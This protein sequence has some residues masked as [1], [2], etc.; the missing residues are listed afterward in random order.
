MTSAIKRLL[1]NY[2]NARQSWE[3]WCYMIN[4]NCKERDSTIPK[5]I[6]TNELLFHLRYLAMKDF[7]IEL[8]KILK[9]TKNNQ[10]NIFTLLENVSESD[11]VIINVL[12]ICG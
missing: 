11:I 6:D 1:K 8:Y 2:S 9:Q 10:D 12:I 4:Y 5:Y 3:S 7:H